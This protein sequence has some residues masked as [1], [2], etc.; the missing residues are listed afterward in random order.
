M[1]AYLGY[2]GIPSPQI[3]GPTVPVSLPGGGTLS[4]PVL[5]SGVPTN[6]LAATGNI[7]SGSESGGTGGSEEGEE[8]NSNVNADKL[9]ADM[10]FALTETEVTDLLYPWFDQT[11]LQAKR[12]T[13][14]TYYRVPEPGESGLC[15]SMRRG[16]VEKEGD[17]S[18]SGEGVGDEKKR[19]NEANSDSGRK[20]ER[21]KAKSTNELAWVKEEWVRA[22]EQGWW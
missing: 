18:R 15:T 7:Q 10:N 14:A 19:E 13:S 16:S 5:Q 6:S 1:H 21:G 2:P 12:S 8:G 20:K 11:E 22:T 4:L 9:E 17:T 3:T